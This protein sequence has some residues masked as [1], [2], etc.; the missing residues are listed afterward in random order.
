M[1]EKLRI[2]KER[3]YGANMLLQK[4]GLITLTWGNVSEIDRALG[5]VAIKPSGVGYDTMCPDDIVVTDLDGSVIEGALRPSSDLPTHLALYKSFPDIGAV[6][7]TH[8]RWATV[9]A[10]AKRSVPMLGTTHADTFY[11]DVPC[12]RGLTE[13]EIKGEYER[14]TGN[15]IAETFANRD[16]EA[17]PGVLVASHGPFTWG[18]DA[19]SAVNNSVVLEEV[20]MMA[21]NTLMM[22]PDAKIQ[23]ELLDKHYLRKHGKNAYYGQG[24]S[25]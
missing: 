5:L 12:T 14:E 23:R 9:F 25:K 21:W 8:S 1:N 10:Q 13:A 18:K 4:N 16:Y 22:N 15:V 17:I 7:H 6:A 2:L 3:V 24:E 20:A 19:I 11:G